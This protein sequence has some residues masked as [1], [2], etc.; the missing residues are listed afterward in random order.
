MSELKA[1]PFHNRTVE[2]CSCYSDLYMRDKDWNTRPI[3]DALLARAEK[4]EQMVEKLIK[5]IE[6]GNTFWMR[7]KA[8][9]EYAQKWYSKMNSVITEWKEAKK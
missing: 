9:A 7:C 2:Q 5:A 1:C 4:A 8:D 3:E 6:Y